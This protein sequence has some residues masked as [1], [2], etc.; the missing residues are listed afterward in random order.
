MLETAQCV[1]G[2]EMAKSEWCKCCAN[3]TIR[4]GAD[5]PVETGSGIERRDRPDVTKKESYE[6]GRKAGGNAA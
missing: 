4:K 2:K 3:I 5:N 1:I 6:Y